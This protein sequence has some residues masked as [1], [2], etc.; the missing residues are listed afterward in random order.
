[1]SLWQFAACIDGWN[2]A[3]GAEVPPEPLSPGEF[4]DLLA[5]HADFVTHTVH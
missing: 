4:D 5:R 1:M 2:R 3:N